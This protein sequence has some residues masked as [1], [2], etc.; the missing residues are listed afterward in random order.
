MKI[1]FNDVE[2]QALMLPPEAREIL[3]TRLLHSLGNAPL[4]DIDEAWIQEAERRY[5]NFRL[6]RTRG[7]SGNHVFNE[8]REEMGWDSK[9]NLR[10]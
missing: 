5:Q 2:K 6:G 3:A 8:I 7:I 10:P 9:N 1:Q 4:N